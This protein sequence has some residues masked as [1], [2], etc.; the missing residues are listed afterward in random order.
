MDEALPAGG[1][2]SKRSNAAFI[3]VALFAICL[4]YLGMAVM[5]LW[6]E[7]VIRSTLAPEGSVLLCSSIELAGGALAALVYSRM[8]LSLRVSSV[9]RMAACIVVLGNLA[10]VALVSSAYFSI[11]LLATTRFVTGLGA[12]MILAAINARITRTPMAKRLF[13]AA[14][15]SFCLAAAATFAFL[16][17]LLPLAQASGLSTAVP[18]FFFL[19]SL[20]GIMIPAASFA[21]H[22]DEL[23]PRSD[24]QRHKLVGLDWL[25]LLML[26]LF[27]SGFNSI[28]SYWARFG[29][30]AGVSTEFV[31]QM[32]SIG[33]LV[34][35]A[36]LSIALLA[37][38]RIGVRVPILICLCFLAL[39]AW[40]SSH[41]GGAPP[42]L[43][44]VLF[45]L[46]VISDQ[47]CA[48]VVV[49]FVLT[50]MAMQDRRGAVTAAAPSAMNIGNVLGPTVAV[51]VS[52][53]GYAS[54]GWTAISFYLIGFI[55][56]LIV[57]RRQV[58]D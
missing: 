16:P 33:N 52:R 45:A 23:R 15:F 31:S 48:V 39:S 4:G 40:I 47:T 36:G 1:A 9:L 41:G 24:A 46:A 12:G 57:S 38:D 6:T 17:S 21:D 54:I 44:H 11:A 27:F 28:Y 55:V 53:F 37:A 29:G 14:H 56:M 2:I 34:A 58:Q 32:L 49:P 22:Q 30:H 50:L 10:T 3:A 20:G 8:G 43:G 26:M 18:V 51:T 25:Q 35:L 13:L 7:G 42:P 5:P 19:A